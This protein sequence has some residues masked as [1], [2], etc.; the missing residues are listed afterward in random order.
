MLSLYSLY[1]AIASADWAT[2]WICASI[3]ATG[4]IAARS[5]FR[6]VWTADKTPFR[7]LVVLTILSAVTLF[8]WPALVAFGLPVVV[9]A[10]L[11]GVVKGC[12]V[13]TR[14]LTD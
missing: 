14:L 2:A 3:V 5:L 12:V 11:V 6:V 10:G 7:A 9:L 8:G 1:L 4:A 13:F